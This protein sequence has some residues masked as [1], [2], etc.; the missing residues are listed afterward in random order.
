MGSGEHSVAVSEVHA[1][2]AQLHV[3]ND[4]GEQAARAYR[5][6][7]KVQMMHFGK[8]SARVLD[9]QELIGWCAAKGESWTALG[10]KEVLHSRHGPGEVR[11]FDEQ[12]GRWVLQYKSLGDEH[13]MHVEWASLVKLRRAHIRREKEKNN[14]GP[15]LRRLE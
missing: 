9:T 3:A 8:R 14:E 5:A 12:M 1:S 7:L 11:S 2:L 10:K 4:N 13:L 15:I 6:A